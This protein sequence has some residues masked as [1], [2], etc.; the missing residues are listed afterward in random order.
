MPPLISIVIPAY[1]A[2]A[3]LAE[4]VDSAL[5]QSYPHTEI[6]VTD[7]GSTDDTARILQRYDRHVTV[8]RHRHNRGL[9]AARDTAIS[10]ARGQF[11]AFLDADDVWHPDK[12]AAQMDAL[13][14]HVL[15]HTRI[16]RIGADG[17]PLPDPAHPWQRTPLVGHCTARLIAHN[18]VTISSVLTRRAL[19]ADYTY[20]R[21][22][23]SCED[24]ALWLA[25]SLHGTFGYLDVPLTR[26]R[27]HGN[28]MTAKT[29]TMRVASL[30]VLEDFAARP[31][32][33]RELRVP[34]ARAIDRLYVDSA[35]A[36]YQSGDFSQAR[37]LFRRGIAALDIPAARR[38][39]LTYLRQ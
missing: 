24:W 14:S 2:A 30:D 18:T 13:G 4:A 38:W 21:L 22:Y 7:D 19:V 25:L 9:V 6:L 37:A 20:P 32:I 3:F 8:L 11:L 31:D 16:V 35:H 17:Q 10:I 27:L 12:L 15:V 29:D 33:P 5:A 36:A 1:N 34:L 23:R 28:N 39:L 26:Y